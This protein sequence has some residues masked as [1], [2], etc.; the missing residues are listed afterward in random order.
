MERRSFLKK[1]A[2]IVCSGFLPRSVAAAFTPPPS[3][4]PF[5]QEFRIHSGPWPLPLGWQNF[6]LNGTPAPVPEA[7]IETKRR[8]A[9]E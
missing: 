9:A 8:T 3:P 5:S 6:G 4:L 1:L 2:A 7:K